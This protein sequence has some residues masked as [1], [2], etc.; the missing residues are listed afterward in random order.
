MIECLILTL[1]NLFITSVHL[2]LNHLIVCL[3]IL[4][5]SLVVVSL[6]VVPAT[7]SQREN[8]IAQL[9]N[10][11]REVQIAHIE[12][13]VLQLFYIGRWRRLH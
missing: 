1:F 8:I 11:Q 3:M 6:L 9:Q 10:E 7:I 12:V 4:I 2:L 13:N 5:V